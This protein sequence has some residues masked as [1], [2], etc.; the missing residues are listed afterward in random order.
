MWFENNVLQPQVLLACAAMLLLS[1]GFTVIKKRHLLSAILFGVM[2]LLMTALCVIRA[3]VWSDLVDA[4][5][6]TVMYRAYYVVV[7]AGSC[8]MFHFCNHELSIRQ[9]HWL[10]LV[11]NWQIGLSRPVE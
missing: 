9:S 5:S 6:A 7:C 2:G 1:T 3:I 8:V 4:E 11:I 10:I